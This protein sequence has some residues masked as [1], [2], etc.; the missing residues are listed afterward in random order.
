MPEDDTPH[1]GVGLLGEKLPFPGMILSTRD[2]LEIT[3]A[4]GVTSQD[5]TKPGALG[6]VNPCMNLNRPGTSSVRDVF[7]CYE[8]HMEEAYSM[9]DYSL[10]MDSLHD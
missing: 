8:D 5:V 4:R 10:S 9:I 1:E 6:I 3:K 2:A 7:V